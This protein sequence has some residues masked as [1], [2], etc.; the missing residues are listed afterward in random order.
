MSHTARLFVLLV[1]LATAYLF[2]LGSAP[3]A[4][5]GERAGFLTGTLRRAD[6]QPLPDARFRV[7]VTDREGRELASTSDA[8]VTGQYSL[9][10]PPHGELRAL[11]FATIT[12]DGRTYRLEMEPL[13]GPELRAT[14]PGE[15][16]VLEFRL[17]ISGPRALAQAAQGRA[18]WGGA[19][20]IAVAGDGTAV[21]PGDAIEVTLEPRGPLIDGTTGGTIV[22]SIPYDRTDSR[23]GPHLPG[24]LASTISDVPIGLYVARARL[25]RPT[26]AVH[27]LQLAPR[28]PALPADR[29]DELALQFPPE[30]V[31]VAPLKIWAY[32]ASPRHVAGAEDGLQ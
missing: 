25:A 12:R 24:S 23:L 28:W 4:L 1:L 20:E 22:R 31:G 32:P 18:G 3:P 17:K 8:D 5:E 6:G 29:R 14:I 26:G 30:V 11:A 16:A 9:R 21:Q 10:L 13:G 15:A 7:V 27:A 19:I 2:L